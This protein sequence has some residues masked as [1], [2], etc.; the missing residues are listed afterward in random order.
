MHNM[1]NQFFNFI[2]KYIAEYFQEKSLMAG[3]R[4]YLQLNSQEDI[5]TF[6][7]SLN[8][9]I[10]TDTFSYKLK[11]GEDYTTPLISYERTPDLII[12]YN[13]PEITPDFLVTLRNRVSDQEVGTVWEGKSLLLLITGE[14]DSITGGSISLQSENM[15]FHTNELS[16]KVKTE[17]AE[18]IVDKTDKIVLSKYIDQLDEERKTHFIN[19]YDYRDILEIVMKGSLSIN[20]YSK[21]ELF[22]DKELSTFKGGNLQKRLEKNREIFTAVKRIKELNLDESELEKYF[23]TKDIPTFKKEDWEEVPFQSVYKSYEARQNLNKK[24]R[25]EL[26]ELKLPDHIK[27]FSRRLSDTAAGKRKHQVIIFTDN[28]EEIEL[29]AFISIEHSEKSSLQSSYLKKGRLADIEIK[30]NRLKIHFPEIGKEPLFEKIVYKHED[31]T[32][33]SVELHICI[34]PLITNVLD[35]F[36]YSYEVNV[37]SKQLVIPM[38]D[39]KVQ[40][41]EVGEESQVT[42][43]ENGEIIDYPGESL[44]TCKVDEKLAE[45][46]EVIRFYLKVSDISLPIELQGDKSVLVPINAARLAQVRREEKM[47]FTYDDGKVVSNE[48]HFSLSSSYRNFIE[49]EIEWLKNGVASGFYQNGSFIK[50]ESIIL[51]DDLR[52]AYSRFL[53]S[54][55]KQAPSLHTWSRETVDRA[56]KY[57]KVFNQHVSSISEEKPAGRIGLNVFY[58]GA[59]HTPEEIWLTPFNPLNVAFRLQQEKEIEQE[60][61]DLTILERLRPDSLLPYIFGE[62]NQVYSPDTQQSIPG[63]VVYKTIDLANVADADLFL[64]KVV[65]DKLSQFEKHFTYYFLSQSKAPFKMN[66]VNVLNDY[67]AIRGLLQWYIEKLDKNPIEPFVLQVFIYRTNLGESSAELFSSLKDANELSQSFQ[68]KLKTTNT[69]LSEDEIFKIIQRNVSFYIKEE[70]RDLEYAHVTFYKMHAKQQFAVQQMN[71]L[72][73]GVSMQ[74]LYSSV[75]S[76]KF[77]ED[78]RSG[79]GTK[80]LNID[81]NLLLATSYYINELAANMENGASNTYVKGR[82]IV[83]RTSYEDIDMIENILEHSVWATFVDPGVE[84]DFFENLFE[85][86]IVIHYSDQYSSSTKY[87]AITV[88]KKSKQFFGAIQDY[89]NKLPIQSG[90][91]PSKIHSIIS[92]FN[93]INGEWLLKIVGSRGQYTREKLSIIAAIKVALAYLDHER[94]LW[95]PVSLEEIL[96]VA[97]A[98]SLNKRNGVFTAK[99]LG[100]SGQHSDDLLVIGLEQKQEELVIH[101][102][103]IEVKVGRNESSVMKKAQE[104][105]EKTVRLLR[106]ELINKQ[107]GFMKK[108]HQNFFVQLFISNAKRM[109]E[110]N[111]FPAREYDLPAS[112]L[113]KLKSGEYEF[114]LDL[115]SYIGQGGIISF[116]TETTMRTNKL[117]EDILKINLPEDDVGESLLKS[118]DEIEK[119]LFIDSSELV[120]ENVL[121]YSYGNNEEEA[122][123]ENKVNRIMKY[124]S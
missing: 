24:T 54:F 97:G 29:E 13:S 95:V 88:T 67:Q 23:M 40:F 3:E 18:T 47:A 62:S 28:Q 109:N 5:E 64:N 79:F 58:L 43:R 46:E 119:W 42:L 71:Q 69:D 38:G 89:L 93:T 16:K 106:E 27:S 86:L 7:Q 78:Y 17:I 35:R 14:L 45:S 31:S 94:I 107:D 118:I 9:I 15:P 82:G 39:Y 26:K 77:E 80:D 4:Y 81:G 111:F 57:L 101:L 85:D 70:I 50:N 65:K 56:V 108:F 121:K 120:R 63:W 99:N 21:M 100:V 41:G 75:P 55:F 8:G 91:N 44:L 84:L 123:G 83:S 61:I 103:P 33:L 10:T 22:K 98:V 116:K 48:F 105:I 30:K 34:L 124:F 19:F 36:Q 53:T 113:E 112:L 72:E 90:I 73:S 49:I 96:R 92:D 102:Y 122:L 2:A 114:S 32:T 104:Q 1:S 37:R 76:R 115:R 60:K 74:G 11:S 87:D 66:I 12:A 59:I 110:T 20:D 25:V 51:P 68:L 6:I 52:E 117:Q